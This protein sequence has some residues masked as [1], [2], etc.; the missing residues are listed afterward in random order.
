MRL[1]RLFA[2]VDG[3]VSSGHYD[4]LQDMIGRISVALNMAQ[5][6]H[7]NATAERLSDDVERRSAQP[8]VSRQRR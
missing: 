5:R 2:S 8:A 1:A 7:R 6:A 3:A 4:E